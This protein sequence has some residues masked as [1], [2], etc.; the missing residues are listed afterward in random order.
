MG[1]YIYICNDQ[2]LF[3]QPVTSKLRFAKKKKKG[4]HK[5]LGWDSG[6]SDRLLS[7]R[8]PTCHKKSLRL[9]RHD[10]VGVLEPTSIVLLV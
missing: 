8:C 1:I 2:I 5:V 3:S 4:L 9:R 7:K 10:Y 6:D